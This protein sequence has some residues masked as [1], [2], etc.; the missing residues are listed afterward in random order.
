MA[1]HGWGGRPPANEEEARQR[2]IDATA[3][4]I[5]RHGVAKTTLSDVA[6]E[7][8]VTRQTVY[9]HLGSISEI[10]S[11]VAARGAED[12]VDRMVSHLEGSR[13]PA[14]AV[15]EGILFCLRTV[16]ND[17][18]LN[19]LLQL[20]D[21]A[22]FSRAATS[23]VMLGYGSAMLRRF[24]VDWADAGVSDDD[25]DGLAEM[26]MRLLISLLDSSTEVPRPEDEVR[27]LL[28]RWLVPALTRS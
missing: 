9:R 7:L 25:L 18:R 24:P 21:T 3:G 16:P 2:I 10:V 28:E 22:T 20:G 8:G 1:R 19:L 13:S 6:A 12:F 17:P 11:V 5:D 15:V 23:P 26:I 14:D 4:L 27:A